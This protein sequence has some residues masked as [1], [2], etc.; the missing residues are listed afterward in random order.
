MTHVT[1][2]YQLLVDEIGPH[3]QA[4]QAELYPAMD[5]LLDR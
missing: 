3:E 2:A 5:R 1:R 4:E